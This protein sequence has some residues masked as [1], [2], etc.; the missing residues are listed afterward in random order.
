[1]SEIAKDTALISTI[2]DL[3]THHA[4]TQKQNHINKNIKISQFEIKI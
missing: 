1:M 2:V 3:S 4:L